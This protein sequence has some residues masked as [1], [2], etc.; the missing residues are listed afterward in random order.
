MPFGG[1]SLIRIRRAGIGLK[2]EGTCLLRANEK[3]SGK[4]G[5]SP[6]RRFL[7]R[8]LLN[9]VRINTW[10]STHTP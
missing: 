6:Q 1:F 10:S 4:L 8:T 3:R 2:T 7:A 9:Q 5:W